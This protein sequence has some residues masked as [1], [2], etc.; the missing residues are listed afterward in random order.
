MDGVLL[1]TLLSHKERILIFLAKRNAFAE[2]LEISTLELAKAL[3][4]SQQTA[5]RLLIQLEDEGYVVRRRF[6]KARK[7]KLT[8]KGLKELLDIY[9]TLKGILERPIEVKLEGRVFTGLSEGA[10]YLQI[11]YYLK[12]FEE[13]LGFKPYPGTLNIRLMNRD[14]I[15]NKILL[16]KAADIKIDGFSDGRRTYGGA[17]C[18]FARLNDCE[19]VAII[20]IERTHY[21]EDV[22]EILAPT[23]LREKLGL[24]DGDRVR[25]YVRLP[26]KNLYQAALRD[27]RA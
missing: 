12:Q 23:C 1:M 26:S 2:S 21:G 25:L 20:F 6:G 17:R 3:N 10:Y 15:M 27:Y 13:K 11:P 19:D 18:I 4:I 5:S 8:E 9:L 24:R 22:I 14:S 7:I 16:E